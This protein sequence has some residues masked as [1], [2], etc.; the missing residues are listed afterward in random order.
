[1]ALA[2]STRQT[3]LWDQSRHRGNPSEFAHVIPARQGTCLEISHDGWFAALDASTRPIIMSPQTYG[4][5]GGDRV[6]SRTIHVAP[7]TGT[8]S[9]G[10]SVPRTGERGTYVMILAACAVVWRMLRRRRS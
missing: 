2:V 9:A 10:L 4:G 1:M 6:A 7:S 8:V 3:V 5:G